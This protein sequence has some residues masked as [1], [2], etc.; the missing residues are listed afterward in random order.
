M[1]GKPNLEGVTQLSTYLRQLDAVKRRIVRAQS[2][3]E[4]QRQVIGMARA[5]E[6]DAL[7]NINRLMQEMDIRAP[8]NT[9]YEGRLL[10]VL[11]ELSIQ[12]DKSSS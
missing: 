9:G 10:W 4:E 7:E 1:S 11:R 6:A 8:G 12:S 3:I 2:I 5:G